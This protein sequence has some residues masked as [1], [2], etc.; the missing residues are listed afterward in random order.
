MMIVYIYIYMITTLMRVSSP[1]CFSPF[2]AFLAF[3][4]RFARLPI[5]FPSCAV[6]SK[7]FELLYKK[8]LIVYFALVA[9]V[10]RSTISIYI[11]I[12]IYN[13]YDDAN[14]Y[15][16]LGRRSGGNSSVL[17]IASSCNPPL[18]D[19]LVVTSRSVYLCN[20]RSKQIDFLPYF[21]M[22]EVRE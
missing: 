22:R 8:I 9:L 20:K 11:Y 21:D 15:C 13:I 18:L 6:D 1:F 17:L 14:P 2:F 12:Y 10:A 19:W 16:A 4:M 5:T 7:N 3:L